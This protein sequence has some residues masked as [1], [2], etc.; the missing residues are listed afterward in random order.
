[1]GAC[2]NVILI[3]FFNVTD[4]EGHINGIVRIKVSM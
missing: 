2:L 4:T 1:M 3:L